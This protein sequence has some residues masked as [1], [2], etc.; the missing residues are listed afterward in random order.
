MEK[1]FFKKIKNSQ[2][3]EKKSIL[4]INVSILK[5]K[6]SSSE[7]EDIYTHGKIFKF[8]FAKMIHSVSHSFIN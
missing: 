6:D 7:I 4:F 3:I 2:T 5:V 8:G 1:D